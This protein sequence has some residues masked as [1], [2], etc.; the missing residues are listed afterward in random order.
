MKT[1]IASIILLSAFFAFLINAAIRISW[2]I[3][4]IKAIINDT[5]KNDG[6]WSA[7]KL[8]MFVSFLTVLWS[9]HYEI[10]KHGFN[11]DAF[12]VMALIATG[13]KITDAIGKKLNPTI[14]PLT[15]KP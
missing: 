2:S 12:C 4:V 10:V 5:L 14:P 8:T 11:F 13:V 1:E 15:D 9:Y 6:K 7:T 3:R